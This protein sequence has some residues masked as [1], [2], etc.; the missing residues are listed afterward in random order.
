MIVMDLEMSGLEPAR[1]SILSIGAL[2]FSNPSNQFYMECRMRPHAEAD[3]EALKVNGFTIEQIKDKNKPSLK[4][5]L[6][7]FCDWMDAVDDRTIAGH[8]VQFDIRF[9]K[10]SFAFYDTDYKIG[11]RCVD[12][13][14]LAY[15]SYLKRK[16][17]PPMKGNLADI[18]SN[19]LFKYCGLPEEPNPHNALTAT[20]MI[21]ESISRLLYGK[22]LFAHYEKFK[23]PKYLAVP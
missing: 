14:A 8:N 1:H 5:V 10:Y 18:T 16:E 12:S 4:E 6:S 22:V 21:A 2:D 3:P 20:K 19:V 11:S 15:V 7:K 23:V 17:K 13:Y 9:L